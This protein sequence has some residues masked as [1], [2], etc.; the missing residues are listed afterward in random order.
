MSGASPWLVRF[1]RPV[2]GLPPARLT[3]VCF[4]HAGAGA[5]VFHPFS[6]LLPADI[7][8][9]AVVPPGREAR[10]REPPLASIPAMAEGAVAAIAAGI[11]GPV[12]FF[13]HSMGAMIAFEAARSCMA[14]AGPAPRHLFLSGRRAADRASG[15]LPLSGLDDERFV[16]EMV[17]RYEGIPAA[18]LQDREL[19]ALFLPIMRAD[20]RAI[21]SY[22]CADG[23]SLDMPV[24][25]MGGE[26]DP[27][28]TDEA[29][30]GW[31]GRIASPVEKLRFPGGHFYL[32]DDRAAVVAALAKRLAPLV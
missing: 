19:L 32:M 28:C 4:P 7:E 6:R 24:T 12:A 27:Q 11:A 23:P 15:E 25:L 13:G 17:R 14:G 20:I 10:L 30:R 22:R 29:W 5:A 26:T 3:L 31:Q 9:A 8:V 21:E 1:R 18:I 2:A 16:A